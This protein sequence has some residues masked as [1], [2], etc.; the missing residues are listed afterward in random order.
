MRTTIALSAVMG[1]AMAVPSVPE[2]VAGPICGRSSV[3]V[4]IPAPVPVVSWAE[5]IG[6]DRDGDLW[7]SRTLQNV[8]DRYDAHGRHVG[9]VRVH[10]PGS[11]RLGP[12]GRMYATSGDNPINMVPGLPLTG[13]IVSF[14]PAERKPAVTTIARGL[15]MPNGLAITA[16]GTMYVGDSNLGV[17]KV[18][19]NGT[20]D[21]AWTARA[22]KNLAPNRVVNGT[23]MNGVVVSGDTA[24]V[25]MTSSLSS[26]ILRIPLSA[27]E[28]VGVAADLTAPLPGSVDDLALV[29]DRA[30]A[31]ATATG[32]VIVVDLRTGS[33]CTVN[34]GRPLT[35]VAV[36]PDGRSLVVASEDGS[37]AVVR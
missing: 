15:G 18:R 35:S 4:L 7:V 2:A 21:R 33:R 31:A 26:R 17:V 12:D 30:I 6:Y 27:P 14:D 8:I 28:R 29:G 16:D 25:A 10:A 22:P 37:V 11:V 5:N 1:L 19:K 9:A 32:Q 34:A 13:R 20:I 23:G 3:R 24:Y 36:A